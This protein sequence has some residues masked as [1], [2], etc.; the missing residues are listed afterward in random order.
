MF[1]QLCSAQ[2]RTAGVSEADWFKYG[3]DLDW[4][5]E[6]DVTTEDFI[7]ADF[8]EGDWIKLTI[9]D[10]SETNVTG[11]FTIHY[12]NG[13]ENFLTSSVDLISGEGDLRNW[14]ISGD[15]ITNNPLY[16]TEI[17]EIINET[18][19]Q[20]YPWGSRQTNHLVYLLNTSSGEDYSTLNLDLYWD[21]EIG[22]LTEMSFEAEMQQN[23]TLM[24]GSASVTL[25]EM[26]HENIPEF[27]QPAI[28][29]IIAMVP[30][31]ISILKIKRN[32]R[33]TPSS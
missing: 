19:T 26:S 20:T 30:F 15:L 11:Q 13:T 21:Q 17:D 18:I 7:F 27:T 1:F 28:I 31:L 32:L 6:L 23:G 24:A 3:L 16:E 29:L 10:V 8:L 4:N 5:Y 9:Q 22:I 14:L 12:E 33:L 2:V 25:T